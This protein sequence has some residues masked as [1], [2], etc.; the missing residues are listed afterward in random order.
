MVRQ[1]DPA[2]QLVFNVNKGRWVFEP[3][4]LLQ[5]RQ[6]APGTVTDGDCDLSPDSPLQGSSNFTPG[7]WQ[8]SCEPTCKTP[9]LAEPQKKV[10]T[11]EEEILA[12]HGI[13]PPQPP[14]PDADSDG[15]GDDA[16]NCP[17]AANPLQEDSDDDA[18][19]DVCDNCPSIA[20][21]CQEDA[22]FDGVGDACEG[23]VFTDGFE[24]GD[25]SEWT[26]VS[27]PP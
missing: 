23:L 25:V 21:P 22:D 15:Y 3:E 24:S 14:P 20:N 1:L 18:V 13:L 9:P 12:S 11:R 17:N 27:P 26:F 5:V 2:P 10:L 8:L 7:V 6:I 16:D 4:A 19:G